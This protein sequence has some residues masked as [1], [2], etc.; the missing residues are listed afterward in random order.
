MEVEDLDLLV[1]LYNQRA[2]GLDPSPNSWRFVSALLIPKVTNIAKV[3]IEQFR[4]ISIV[5]WTMKIYMSILLALV[6]SFV[7]PSGFIQFGNRKYHQ[8]A[9]VV[10]CI[11]ILLEKCTEWSLPL[12]VISV[13]IRKAFD[14]LLPDAIEALFEECQVP[15]RLRLAFLQQP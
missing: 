9:E 10:Q 15:A 4:P 3:C 8:C 2:E 1:G 11:R 6:V 5:A 7:E 13:D 12:I 14:T